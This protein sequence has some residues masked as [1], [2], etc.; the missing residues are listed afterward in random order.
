LKIFAAPVSA[1]T[2]T[3]ALR[4]LDTSYTVSEYTGGGSRSCDEN[5]NSQASSSGH[6]VHLP[7]SIPTS[8]SE[9]MPR[10][11]AV[12]AGKKRE[13]G[14]DDRPYVPTHQQSPPAI[15]TTNH[16][17]QLLT[18]QVSCKEEDFPQALH[19]AYRYHCE[20]IIH[21]VRPETHRYRTS[22]RTPITHI[23]DAGARDHEEQSCIFTA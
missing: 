15:T 6:N 12:R 5:V 8:I 2:S 4:I 7:F 14:S 19:Q 9:Y 17:H 18:R 16:H 11:T 3:M 1:L 22:Q 23:L 21:L 10:T 20:D 13:R